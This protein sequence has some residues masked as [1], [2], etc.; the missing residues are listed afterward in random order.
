MPSMND[1]EN[2]RPDEDQQ[3]EMNFC[4]LKIVSFFQAFADESL[5]VGAASPVQT[6]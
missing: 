3:A 2:H 5:L 6:G 1:L 4:P